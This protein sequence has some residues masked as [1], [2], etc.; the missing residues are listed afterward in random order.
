MI[1]KR[2]F[3]AVLFTL[4]VAHPVPA[5]D[6]GLSAEYASCMDKSGGVTMKVLDCM[7][8]ETARQDD[9]LNNAYKEILRELPPDRKRQLRDVQR[10]WIKYRDANCAFYADPAGGSIARIN[11]N[12]CFLIETAGRA[13]E[14]ENLKIP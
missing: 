6:L 11:A 8:A 7:S 2:V 12:E 3:I 10:L 1:H 13:K 14:L 4:F 5:D 9:R